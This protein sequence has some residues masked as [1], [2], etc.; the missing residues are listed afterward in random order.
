MT[1]S[2]SVSDLFSFEHVPYEPVTKSLLR[3]SPVISSLSATDWR[4]MARG[5]LSSIQQECHVDHWDGPG[6]KSVA[7]P[8]LGA[9]FFVIEQLYRELPRTVPGPDIV[10]ETDGEIDF[11]WYDRD[12]HSVSMSIS[13][14]FTVT[15]AANYG[16]KGVDHGWKQLDE[17]METVVRLVVRLYQTDARRSRP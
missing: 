12:G 13:P 6:S 17:A 7:E 10:P 5:A 4:P 15:Y 16:K 2:I 1:A 8:T 9:A 14:R 3:P 11:H